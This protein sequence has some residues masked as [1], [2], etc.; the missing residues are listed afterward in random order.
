MDGQTKRY[1]GIYNLA[2][3]QWLAADGKTW[4]VSPLK[5]WR[6]VSMGDAASKIR[7]CSVDAQA[8]YEAYCNGAILVPK[9]FRVIAPR[10]AIRWCTTISSS[11]GLENF[12]CGGIAEQLA[13]YAHHRVD[14]TFR[15]R[16]KTS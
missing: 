14:V 9:R 7:N 4:S 11:G 5:R 3:E 10:G 15:I 13:R 16:P 8:A 1:W 6:G 12:I 2:T